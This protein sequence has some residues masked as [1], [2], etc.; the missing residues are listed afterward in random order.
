VA[1]VISKIIMFLIILIIIYVK[2]YYDK[3]YEFDFKKLMDYKKY[4]SI[5]KIGIPSSIR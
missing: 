1:T 4:I 2:R 3:F 5:L